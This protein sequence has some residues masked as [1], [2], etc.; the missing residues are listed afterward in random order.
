M[1]SCRAGKF[2][3]CPRRDGDDDDHYTPAPC[4]CTRCGTRGRDSSKLVIRY[5]NE[6]HLK[7]PAEAGLVGTV[8]GEDRWLIRS[9]PRLDNDDVVAGNAH[10]GIRVI[11]KLPLFQLGVLI[12]VSG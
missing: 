2:C 10:G 7:I 3:D 1:E 11:T 6:S 5:N 9:L 12:N 8:D 4:Q